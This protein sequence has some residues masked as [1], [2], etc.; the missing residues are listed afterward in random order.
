MQFSPFQPQGNSAILTAGVASTSCPV[1]YPGATGLNVGGAGPPQIRLLNL[2]TSMTWLNFSVPTYGVG[3]G[4]PTSATGTAVI[5]VAG[6]TTLGTPQPVIW[7][8]PGIEITLT[9]PVG[10]ARLTGVAGTPFGFWL[11]Y[12]SGA[13]AQNFQLQIGDGT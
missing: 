2:G 6:T 13:A 7:I 9:I 5:P 1:V 11:N 4:D 3:G 12:I 10:I 8:A